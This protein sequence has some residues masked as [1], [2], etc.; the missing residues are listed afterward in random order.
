MIS[1]GPFHLLK[2]CDSVVCYYMLLD[3]GCMYQISIVNQLPPPAK[4]SAALIERIILCEIIN[5]L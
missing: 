2:F 3:A 1:R 5:E 4:K